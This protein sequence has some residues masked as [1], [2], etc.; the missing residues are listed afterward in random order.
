VRIDNDLSGSGGESMVIEDRAG[1]GSS[2]P[3]PDIHTRVLNW[4]VATCAAY[5]TAHGIPVRRSP[6]HAGNQPNR[7][8]EPWKMNCCHSKP[9]TP[10]S[11]LR[12]RRMRPR[13]FCHGYTPILDITL[14]QHAIVA[15]SLVEP[16][17]GIPYTLN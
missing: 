16:Q 7:W 1:L 9:S 10:T 3:Q 8:A 6:R 15:E 12:R 11:F 17:I 14:D 2:V 5:A 4:S 13:P